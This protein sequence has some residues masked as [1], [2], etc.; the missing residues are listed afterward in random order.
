MKQTI[1]GANML[2]IKMNV[3][4]VVH[5]KIQFDVRTSQQTS[6]QAYKNG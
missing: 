3:K 4:E 6:K 5:A 1:S 2:E